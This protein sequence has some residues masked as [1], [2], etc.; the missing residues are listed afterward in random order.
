MIGGR[1]RSIRIVCPG[2][3]L[4][5]IMAFSWGIGTIFT[6]FS[7]CWAVG[8]SVFVFTSTRDK[9]IRVLF[10]PLFRRIESVRSAAPNALLKSRCEAFGR[11]ELLSDS[12]HPGC[13][14]RTWLL[15]MGSQPTVAL[16][17]FFVIRRDGRPMPASSSG[18]QAD[19]PP[20]CISQE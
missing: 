1:H 19:M 15:L 5:E 16:W 11:M 3:Q 10:L 20:C 2:R 12:Y 6:C 8:G 14:P 7:R 17:F 4:W 9:C 13:F 18:V